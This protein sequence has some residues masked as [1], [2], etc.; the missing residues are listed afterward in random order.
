MPKVTKH[1]GKGSRNVLLPNRVALSQLTTGR[2][3]APSINDY[4]KRT[5]SINETAPK[6][7]RRPR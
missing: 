7:L 1:A 2:P 6:T 5:A 4:A 3:P